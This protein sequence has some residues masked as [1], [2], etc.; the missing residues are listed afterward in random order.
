[1]KKRSF[2]STG[3]ELTLLGL[4]GFHLLEISDEDSDALCSLYLDKGGNYIETAPQYGEGESERKIGRIMEHRRNECF[5]T[6]KSHVRDKEGAARTIEE[7]LKRLKTDHVDLLLFHHVQTMDDYNEI[8]SPGGAMEAF[9]QARKEGKTRFIGLSGHG[10]PDMLIHA[11]RERDDLD[12]VMTA[13]NFFD[14]FHFPDTESVLVEEAKKKGMGIIGMKALAD[15]LLW[16]YPETAIRYTLSQPVDVLPLGMNTPEMLEKDFAIAENFSPLS[17]DEREE[18]FV[19]NPILGSYI[20]RQCGKCLPCPEGIDIPKVFACEG[21]YDRQLRDWTVRDMPVFALRERL[22]FWYGNRDTAK[23]RYGELTVNA[24]KCTK[25][26]KCLP[27]CPY[28]IDI[29]RKLACTH[30][31]LTREEVYS[32]NL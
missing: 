10:I 8:F 31:K 17:D 1:M 21:W 28:S 20:C 19:N 18:V 16:E 27:R 29:I 23:Q 24:E 2:G 9:L 13:F 14:R 15:G 7:S 32:V 26:G 5:L 25:C 30:Y 3:D 22:R 6:T 12:A 4:G 11:I